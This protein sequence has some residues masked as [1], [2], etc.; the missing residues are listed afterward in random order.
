[1]DDAALVQILTARNDLKGGNREEA[2]RKK[3]S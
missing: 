2:E 3:Q 1:M